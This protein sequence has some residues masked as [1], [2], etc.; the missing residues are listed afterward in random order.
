M[1]TNLGRT[2]VTRRTPLHTDRLVEMTTPTNPVFNDAISSFRAGFYQ[3]TGNPEGARMMALQAV[4]MV[5]QQQSASMAFL[6]SFGLFAVMA[7]ALIPLA[8]WMRR[9]V[10]EEETHIG[11]ESVTGGARI[12]G[13]RGFTVGLPPTIMRDRPTLPERSFPECA[14]TAVILWFAATMTTADEPPAGSRWWDEKVAASLDRSPGR[15]ADWEKALL[16]TEPAHRAGTAY[17]VTHLPERDLENLPPAKL[18]E[19]I[20]LAYQARAEVP[21]GASLPDDVFLDA[22]L[23]HASLTEPR[24]PM[25][26]EFHDK[27]LPL[28]R[29]CRTPGEP[30]LRMNKTL[31]K[32]YGVTYN[33]RRLRTDQSSKESIAQGMATC[34]G[35]AIMLVEACRSVGVPARVAGIASWPGRGGNHT[36]AEVWDAGAWHFVGAAEPDEKGLDHAWFV[37]DAAKAVKETPRNAVWAATY[38]ATGALFPLAW[39]A[40]ARVNGENV[41]DRY[42]RGA[43]ESPAAAQ[44][45]LMVEVRQGG[46]RVE[47]EVTVLERSTGS[48]KLA[49]TSLGPEADINRHLTGAVGAGESFLVVARR[50]NRAASCAV[51]VEGD[52]VVRLDLDRPTPPSTRAELAAILADRFGS[53]AEKKS[54]ARKILAEA[55]I[56]DEARRLAWAAY[57]VSPAHEPLRKEWEAK[58]VSTADRTSPYLWRH[59]GND[60]GDGWGLVIAMHGGGG[61][62]KRVNDKQWHGMYERYYKE[63]PEAGGYV[64]LALRAPNDEWNGFYDDAI[65]PMVERLIRQFVLF[66]GVNPDR[67]YALGASHGGYGAFVIGPKMPDRFAAVHA[68]ASAP[69]DGETFGENL[70]DL[71]FT[72]MVGE[73]DTAYGRA[74]RCQAFAKKLENWRAARGGY[75]GAFEWRPGVGHSVPDRDKVGE[76]LRSGARNPWP[77]QVVWVQSDAVLRHDYWVET[78]RPA[79]GARVE[80]GVEGNTISLKAE[81]LDEVALWLD[82]DL[83]DLEKPVTVKVTG[84]ATRTF[85][86]KPDLET[87]CLGLDERGDPRLAAPVRVS[88]GVTH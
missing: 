21:W 7:L 6:D 52:T 75:P 70:R 16:A 69:T 39:N 42:R 65:C 9:S 33:T 38:R 20:A 3:M 30:A 77:A 73:K 74:D 35:L 71:R 86:P 4:D 72:F 79:E 61:A 66:G 40:R 80:A 84:G 43:P 82:R 88:V 15:K 54:V 44:P 29:D 45:R 68:S 19:N 78:P 28:V 48:A 23:P 83:V 76:M 62:P 55:P 51:R 85:N 26:A 1:G 5:R 47:A 13:G 14:M 32:D 87:Y 58:T 2:L 50:G 22:V 37:G 67:V 59:V 56:D 18:A 81:K 8:L 46:R 60:P 10:A 57:R 24:D 31:F 36:W 12:P 34:T 17:L 53:D 63:H 41:T 27:Y 25:R 64:Y 11:A 49:G